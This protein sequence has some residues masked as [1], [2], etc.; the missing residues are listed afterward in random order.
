MQGLTWQ[1]RSCEGNFVD[2]LFIFFKFS[3]FH[4]FP[5]FVTLVFYTSVQSD[6]AISSLSEYKVKR[7]LQW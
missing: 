5:T 4:L 6:Q 3:G 1:Q 2:L 7:V